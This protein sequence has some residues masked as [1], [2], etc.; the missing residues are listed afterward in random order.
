MQDHIYA[1]GSAVVLLCICCIS[2]YTILHN[3]QQMRISG[4]WYMLHKPTLLHHMVPGSSLV[5]KFLF[6]RDSTM[7]IH[8]LL[9]F[10]GNTDVPQIHETNKATL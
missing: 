2:G 7:K 5:L 6:Q 10:H 9:Y 1:R 4:T 8:K 3:I